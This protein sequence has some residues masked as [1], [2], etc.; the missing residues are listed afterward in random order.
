MGDQ[1]N[2]IIYSNDNNKLLFKVHEYKSEEDELADL[3]SLLRDVKN[4]D[5]INNTIAGLVCEQAENLK[6]IDSSLESTSTVVDD[7]VQQL[8]QAEKYNNSS[9][10]KKSMIIVTS[11]F[12]LSSIPLGLLVGTNAGI[13]SGSISLLSGGISFFKK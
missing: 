3:V 4:I 2:I 5:T 9:L 11:V 1:Q 7:G 12:A 10:I 6:R 8:I 13:I